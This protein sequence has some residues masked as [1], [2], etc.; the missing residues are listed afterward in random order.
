MISV[1]IAVKNGAG[2]IRKC[3]EGLLYQRDMERNFE[4]IVIDDGSNDGT[5]KIAEDMGVLVIAQSNAGP[6]SARNT[7]AKAAKGEILAFIDAD[8]IP[9]SY[10]LKNLT[11]PFEKIDI[12]GTKGVYRTHQQS[13]IARFV[14]QEYE[15]KYIRLRQQENIDFID[16]YS[17]AYR[18][19]IFLENGGFEPAFPVPSVEDQEFSFRLARKGYLMVFSPQAIVY[20][21]H[22][23][24]YK[25]YF[26][27]KFGIGYWKAFMLRWVPEKAL[28]DSH[29]LPS[30][31]WQILFLG[32]T[33]LM[34]LIGF[35]KPILFWISLISLVG[36]YLTTLPLLIQLKRNDPQV[37]WVAHQLLLIRSF[38]QLAGLITGFL[39]PPTYRSRQVAGLKLSSRLSKRILDILIGMVGAIISLPMILIIAVLIKLDDG[40]PVIYIQERAGENGKPFR[41]YKLRTMYLGAD[42]QIKSMLDG[43]LLIGPV[44][45]FANDPR[46]TRFGQFLRRWSLDE[47]PQ[48]WNV[49]KGDMSIVGPRPEETWVVSQYNDIQRQRLAVK[50]GITG[51]MQVSGRGNLDMEKRLELEL[52]YINSYS[53]LKDLK[54]ILSTLPAVIKGNGAY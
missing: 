14:Q 26:K 18:R 40:G 51:P 38:A 30:Q 3:I 33:C 47:L 52:D 24:S 5:K 27:R 21:K 43:N 46:V 29:T 16:T 23:N 53:I 8:C 15:S 12:V 7:G 20:H 1:I 54:I 4:V 48:F 49:L 25:E 6:A 17:A 28:S 22:D 32:I 36:F 9:D 13:L 2:T 41:M 39:F 45:K 11:K 37:L 34:T 42:Q 10:W 35:V 31:R 19:D 50:P 44:F